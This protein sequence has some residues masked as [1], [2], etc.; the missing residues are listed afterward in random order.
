MTLISCVWEELVVLRYRFR[1]REPLR[2]GAV[3]PS[4]YHHW[5]WS[6]LPYCRICTDRHAPGACSK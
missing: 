4:A 1:S 5:K 6:K 3:L 2:I